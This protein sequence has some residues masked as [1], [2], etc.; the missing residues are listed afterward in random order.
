[1]YVRTEDL[2]AQGKLNAGVPVEPLILRANAG[3]CIEVNLTNKLN[4]S[5]SVFQQQMFMAPPFAGVNPVNRT[6]GVQ[7][8]DVQGSW[9]APAASQPTIR[10]Q[11]R[12][13]ISAGTD[14][15]GRINWQPSETRLSIN[16]TQDGSIA[17]REEP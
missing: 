7:I 8:A 13:R 16:G 15:A 9:S 3:D 1:M 11:A 14:R 12:E 6:A 17:V 2:N 5:A 10:R 4:P